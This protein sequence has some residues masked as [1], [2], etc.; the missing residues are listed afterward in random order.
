MVESIGAFEMVVLLIDHEGWKLLLKGRI[1]DCSVL[2]GILFPVKRVS[3][4]SFS[5]E[6]VGTFEMV[7]LAIDFEDSKLFLDGLVPAVL[8]MVS[9]APWLLI[10]SMGLGVVG[11]VPFLIGIRFA[12][13][14]R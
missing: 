7:V 13:E 1:S 12:L 4:P 9:S 10:G 14:G 2:Y 11:M 8:C 3:I 5:F 6:N